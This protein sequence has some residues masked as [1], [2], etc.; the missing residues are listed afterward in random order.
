[1]GI[2]GEFCEM[3]CTYLCVPRINRL[4]R[5]WS[6]QCTRLHASHRFE[7]F[8]V[9]SFSVCR[10][11][12]TRC[13]WYFEDFPHFRPIYQKTLQKDAYVKEDRSIARTL[14]MRESARKHGNSATKIRSLGYL[15]GRSTLP[16]PHA[17][18]SRRILSD[19]ISGSSLI[20]SVV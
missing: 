14:G 19:L 18:V 10:S 13:V 7:R 15:L 6:I 4:K 20:V 17:I 12:F 8:F 11:G 16:W 2:N 1:M 5:I 3:C 9:D